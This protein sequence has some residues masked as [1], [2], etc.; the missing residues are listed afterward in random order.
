MIIHHRLFL[1]TGVEVNINS[2]TGHTMESATIR[3]ESTNTHTSEPNHVQLQTLHTKRTN[4]SL[5][6]LLHAFGIVFSS[7]TTD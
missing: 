2:F 3:P 6:R 5:S 1:S 4:H 7:A